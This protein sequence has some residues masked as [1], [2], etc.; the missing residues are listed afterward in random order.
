MKNRILYGSVFLISAVMIAYQL[1]LMR[2]FTI[3]QWHNFAYMII[4]IAMLGFGASGTVL[5]LVKRRISGRERALFRCAALLLGISF[6]ASYALSQKVGFETFELMSQPGQMLKA[7]LLYVILALPFFLAS[8]CIT[9]SFLIIPKQI[10]RLYF[11]NMVGS[12]LGA[13]CGVYLMYLAHPAQ[14]PYILAVPP[15]AVCFL[16]PG[17]SPGRTKVFRVIACAALLFVVLGPK[18]PIR[19]SE[20]KGLSYAKQFPDARVV[21]ERY[22]PFSVITAISSKQIR[23]TP[24][25]IAG[26]PMRELGPLPEQIGLFFD[27]GGVSPVNRFDGSFDSFAYLDYVTSAVAYRLVEK[28][29][30]LV[31]GAGGGTDVLGALTHGAR[32]VT[33]LEI[34]PCVVE[35]LAG[36]L[37]EFSGGLFDRE[38]VSSVIAEGRGYLQANDGTFDLIQISLLDSFNASSA[39]VHALN[40]SYL[41]TEEAF[42][43]YISRLE[44]GGVLSLTR[45]V[46]SPPRDAL[47]MFATAVEACEMANLTPASDH[48]VFIRSWNTAT[49]LVSKSPLDTAAIDAVKSFAKDR[50]LDLCHYPGIEADETNRYT[51]LEGPVYYEVAQALLSENREDAYEDFLFHI[52]PA[53]DDKPY[54][55]RFF[56]WSSM[57]RLIRGMGSEWVPFVEWGYAVLI[58]TLFQAVA[59]SAFLILIPL[60]VF[61]RSTGKTKAKGWVL[62]CTAS[63]GLAY[64]FLE[65]AFIQ[66]F[67]LLLVYPIYAVSVVLTAL[68]IFSGLGSLLA[69]RIRVKRAKQATIAVILIGIIAI[70][71]LAILPSIIEF[72]IG[73]PDWARIIA[74]V[75]LIA[76]IAFCMGIPFPLTMQLIAEKSDSLLPWAWGIN[77]CA[78]VIAACTATVLAIHFGFSRVV[79]TAAITYLIAAASLWR[80]ENR[81]SKCSLNLCPSRQT[82]Q[83]RD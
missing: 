19:I 60:V 1:A 69:N 80:I 61:A 75:T 65:I 64:T 51:I 5:S 73:W 34:D 63:L 23:E 26:Y 6:V 30:V 49:L 82:E 46:K 58:V 55:F 72:C 40:E 32:H 17:E 39:G 7:L 45:W 11:F 4:S 41:Y 28:P 21:D 42:A 38:D 79:I 13:A 53:T 70:A 43:L 50:G 33:A 27:A 9:L 76:P 25:Q 62:L 78:S 36:P 54:F 47:K 24:G 16:M 18:T 57:P 66:R 3:S 37:N 67:M 83:K 59:A 35:I 29:N 8:T 44:P 68:L 20:Y 77:G 14:I 56:K 48:L 81:L 15:I 71:Y 31:I 74:S 52:K 10:G 22:G 2:V 12:G